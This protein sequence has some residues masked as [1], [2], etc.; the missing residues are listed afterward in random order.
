MIGL[1]L[2]RVLAVRAR[3]QW[4]TINAADLCYMQQIIAETFSDVSDDPH[5]Y[6]FEFV[7]HPPAWAL[8]V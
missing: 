4:R 8:E 1:S 2:K 5:E 6:G 3:K 7:D